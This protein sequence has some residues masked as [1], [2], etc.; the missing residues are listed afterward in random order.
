VDLVQTSGKHLAAFKDLI[1]W[2]G[3]GVIVAGGFLLGR[4]ELIPLVWLGY[5]AIYLLVVPSSP[6]YERRLS[7]RF[8]SQVARGRQ[9]LRQ[10]WLP[11]LLPEDRQRY[12]TLESQRAS[13]GQHTGDGQIQQE[14]LGKLDDLLERF[15]SFGGKRAEYL[16]YLRQL[17]QNEMRAS[18]VNRGW[19]TRG[20]T[21][22]AAREADQLQASLTERYSHE[23][24]RLDQELRKEPADSTAEVL[25]KNVEVLTRC[26]DNLG[27][28]GENLRNLTH[29]MEL[30]ENTFTLIHGQA[31]ARAPEQVLGEIQDVVVSSEALSEALATFAPLDEAVQRL[32]RLSG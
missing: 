14:I 17:R 22:G 28:I 26:R 30:V 31:R 24:E 13:I 16:E 1:N 18:P 10:Q 9:E 25:K 5:E 27:Q 2:I 32:G 20:E 12:E 4:P 21:P 3:T 11:K 6:W 23:I 15:L 29:Q 7:R 8:E 19:W